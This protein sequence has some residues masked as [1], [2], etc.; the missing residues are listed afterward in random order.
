[1]NFKKVFLQA[2]I[3]VSVAANSIAGHADLLCA[4]KTG[5][6]FQ[7]KACLFNETLVLG[8]P[9]PRGVPGYSAINTTPCNEAVLGK[10]MGYLAGAGVNDL[11][12]CS[13]LVESTGVVTGTCWQY[14]Y[15]G[16]TYTITKGSLTIRNSPNTTCF[17]DSTIKFDT[18]IT[19]KIEGGLSPDKNTIIGV[20]WNGAG[21]YGTFNA[22]RVTE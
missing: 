13:I 20:H 21:G 1:M 3:L 18:G 15:G 4:K 7:R 19:A 14:L 16:K 11:E 10:W 12:A 9:G 2:I 5:A 8:T 6:V 17:I 22:I